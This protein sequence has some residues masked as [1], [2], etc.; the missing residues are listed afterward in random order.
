MFCR[1]SLAAVLA[2]ALGLHLALALLPGHGA[3]AD[4]GPALAAISAPPSSSRVHQGM[5]LIAK[6]EMP[7]PRFRE[8]VIFLARHSG[9][10]T[11]GFVV[12]RPTRF[13]LADAVEGGLPL[14]GT[15]HQL[16]YG[17]PVGLENVML[18]V[19][20]EDPPGRALE[21]GSGL[22]LSAE[23]DVL[24]QVLNR[25]VPA[26]NLRLYIGYSGWGA[27]QLARELKQGDWYPIPGSQELIFADRP[28][29]LWDE[30]IEKHAPQGLFVRS[31]VASANRL[32]PGLG[33]APAPVPLPGPFATPVAFRLP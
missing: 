5:F 24:E 22:Y 21:V 20:T 33:P 8:T 29:T 9:E 4:R 7:D 28:Q 6:R 27:G 3:M 2:L 17:G 12:N 11:L 14:T 15:A 18:L 30:L 32:H 16:H 25:G 1:P 10:G 19:R 26:P 23:R 13:T 31:P